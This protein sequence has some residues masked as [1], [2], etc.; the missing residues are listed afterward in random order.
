MCRVVLCVWQQAE[1]EASSTAPLSAEGGR[2][3][4]ED[5]WTNCTSL[6]Q[7]LPQTYP[8]YTS[9]IIIAHVWGFSL[10]TIWSLSSCLHK[11]TNNISELFIIWNTEITVLLL[12]CLKKNHT[13]SCW[14]KTPRYAKS[15]RSEIIFCGKV[16]FHSQVCNEKVAFT[17]TQKSNTLVSPTYILLVH[18]TFGG[19]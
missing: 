14:M 6:C 5:M 18:I 15:E 12:F 2:W 8:C 7:S 13:F 19:L 11:F 16:H 10:V 3:W 4:Q 17:L 9:V 1:G